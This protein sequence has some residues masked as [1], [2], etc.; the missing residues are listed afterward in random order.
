MAGPYS[1]RLKL[2][3][4]Q[5]VHIYFAASVA[6]GTY[7]PVDTVQPASSTSPQDFEVSSNTSIL[8]FTTDETAGEFEFVSGGQPTGR[9]VETTATHAAS[10]SGRPLIPIQLR[11]GV[12][13]RLKQ[14]VAGAA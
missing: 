13:Y 10:N 5:M 11:A 2:A 9:F 1:G 4:G 8:D 6:A 14:V 12:K 3:N 7:L